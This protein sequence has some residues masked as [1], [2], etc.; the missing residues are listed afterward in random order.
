MVV[1]ER[2]DVQDRVCRLVAAYLL[3]AAL[4]GTAVPAG[5]LNALQVPQWSRVV[6]RCRVQTGVDYESDDEAWL[7]DDVPSPEWAG[8]RRSVA[9]LWMMQLP[10]RPTHSSIPRPKLVHLSCKWSTV[11]SP[12][13]LLQIRMT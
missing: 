11:E 8:W 4:S 3:G 9:R 10:R 12:S 6:Q 2:F 13:F 7:R 1:C 5:H